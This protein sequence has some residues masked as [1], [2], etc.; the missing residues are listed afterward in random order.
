MTVSRNGILAGFAGFGR[1]ATLFRVAPI[2]RKPPNSNKSSLDDPF[3]FTDAICL[4][5]NWELAADLKPVEGL[6]GTRL[7]F[8]PKRW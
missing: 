4:F 3:D 1:R 6:G 8:G 7:L 2:P 5:R